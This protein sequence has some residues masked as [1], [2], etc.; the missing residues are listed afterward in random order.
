MLATFRASFGTHRA[1]VGP[2]RA[3]F[4]TDQTSLGPDRVAFGTSERDPKLRKR[5]SSGLLKSA[6]IPTQ[7]LNLY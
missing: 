4:S 7:S 3:S 1:S 5:N 2:D 6:P